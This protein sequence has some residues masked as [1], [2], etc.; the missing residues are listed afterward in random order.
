[1]RTNK[2]PTD[3]R[4]ARR[5][6]ALELKTKGWKQNKIAEALGVSAGAVSQWFKKVAEKGA[7]ALHH[8]PP[9]GKPARLSHQQKVQL[10]EYL[11]AGPEAYGFTGQLWTSKRVA[12]LIQFKFGVKYHRA[13]VSRLLR[14]ELNWSVQ[15]PVEKASQRNEE[16]I[17]KWRTEHWLELKKKPKPK[18]TP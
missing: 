3:W 16:A 18:T 14:Q 11:L 9:P 12:W 6:Q 7:E 1:M 17:E 8:T 4:E 13:H 10:V 2:K 15:K 5:L